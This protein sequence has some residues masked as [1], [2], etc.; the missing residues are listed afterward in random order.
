KAL[1]ARRKILRRI[2]RRRTRSR[3]D[4]L[5][6][7][8]RPLRSRQTPPGPRRPRRSAP[9]P[10]QPKR[11][12]RT[13]R[14]AGSAQVIRANGVFCSVLCTLIP[15]RVPKI[16]QRFSAGSS[17]AREASPAGTAESG[18]LIHERH[19]THENPRQLF[20]P[21]RVFRGL[22]AAPATPPSTTPPPSA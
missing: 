15:R 10:P 12:P 4:P 22:S 9:P 19:E 21:F 6:P 16:A 18:F 2:R 1:R 20:V 11:I 13:P 8:P 14:Q 17:Q 5:P 7:R 3:Q